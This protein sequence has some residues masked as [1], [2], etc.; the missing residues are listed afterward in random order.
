MK[1][2]YNC[3]VSL[4]IIKED[5]IPEKITKLLNLEPTVAYKKNESRKS[6]SKKGKIIEG[7]KFKNGQWS[8]DIGKRHKLTL[9]NCIQECIEL[10]AH[11][12][13]ELKAFDLKG[14]EIDILCG[15]FIENGEQIGFDLGETTIKKLAEINAK[16]GVCVY[17]L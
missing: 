16:L 10:F 1:S 13:D 5:L 3:T 17:V 7:A 6:I 14:Y 9:D 11:C 4:R 2:N 15:I 8:R 12:W